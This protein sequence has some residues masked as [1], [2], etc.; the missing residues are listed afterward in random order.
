MEIELHNG[1]LRFAVLALLLLMTFALPGCSHQVLT[2][3]F[4]GMPESGQEQIVAADNVAKPEGRKRVFKSNQFAHGPY[5][6]SLCNSCHQSRGGSVFDRQVT[7]AVT[8]DPRKISPHLVYPLAELCVGCHSDQQPSAAKANG[9]WQHGPVANQQCTACHSPH[10]S[11]R[12]YMLL[13]DSNAAMCGQ[14]HSDS[15]LRHTPEHTHDP[16]AECTSCHNPHAGQS[17]FLLKAEYDERN[18]FDE[19]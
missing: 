3:F 7:A 1:V 14:C 16:A 10:K 9:L 4:T 8:T 12:R 17:R 11:N 6:A 13:A 5:G 15:E 2:F 19:S 18:R